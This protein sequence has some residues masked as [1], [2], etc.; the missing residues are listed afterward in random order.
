MRWGRAT[1]DLLVQHFWLIICLFGLGLIVYFYIL[2]WDVPLPFVISF[3]PCTTSQVHLLWCAL[4]PTPWPPLRCKKLL[5]PPKG[6]P[7]VRA[8]KAC[9]GTLRLG[10]VPLLLPGPTSPS[11]PEGQLSSGALP[12]CSPPGRYYPTSL[13]SIGVSFSLF[14]APAQPPFSTSFLCR[15]SPTFLYLH[16]QAREA[17]GSASCGSDAVLP[18]LFLA[19]PCT[20]EACVGV[21]ENWKGLRLSQPAVAACSDHTASTLWLNSPVSTSFL[22][23]QNKCRTVHVAAREESV[24][25]VQNEAEEYGWEKYQKVIS[26]RF[27]YFPFSPRF[28]RCVMSLPKGRS[29][30]PDQSLLSWGHFLVWLL[31]T[32]PGDI[33]VGCWLL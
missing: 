12:V 8:S 4:D 10:P 23:A 16:A 15:C 11:C 9:L 13:A 22:V 26:W 7:C 21:K 18:C 17:E 3:L 2:I 30:D 6:N 27:P 25:Q 19:H 24:F 29:Q 20:D 32:R 33:S 28:L 31:S 14:P 1:D 5:F